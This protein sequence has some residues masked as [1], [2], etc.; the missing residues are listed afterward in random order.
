M[1]LITYEELEK[2][3]CSFSNNLCNSAPSWV[4]ATTYWTSSLYDESR[5]YHVRN[6]G[7]LLKKMFIGSSVAGI[8]PVI[9]I[10]KRRLEDYL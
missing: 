1:R 2:L 10:D 9:E 8:R 5:L 4:Y 7:R 3:G 6:N